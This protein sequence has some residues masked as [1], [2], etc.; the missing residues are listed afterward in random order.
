MLPL[1]NSIFLNILAKGQNIQK[2]FKLYTLKG[3]KFKIL[4]YYNHQTY[5]NIFSG[6]S[7]EKIFLV[8][9]LLK[10]DGLQ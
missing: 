2:A 5:K 4:I 6:L 1:F 10:P 3:V 8:L 7:P 9:K